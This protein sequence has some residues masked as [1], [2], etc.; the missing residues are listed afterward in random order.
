MSKH[1]VDVVGRRLPASVSTIRGIFASESE[2][3][4]FNRTYAPSGDRICATFLYD[5]QFS[6]DG[7]CNLFDFLSRYS[8]RYCIQSRY[9]NEVE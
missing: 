3:K 2:R 9:N 6:I 1:D 4:K 8:E 7:T 5:T